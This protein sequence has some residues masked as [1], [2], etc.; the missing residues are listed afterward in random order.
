MES[1]VNHP[2]SSD[3]YMQTHTYAHMCQI[4][5]YRELR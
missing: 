5:R 3:V 1:V 2:C 4:L